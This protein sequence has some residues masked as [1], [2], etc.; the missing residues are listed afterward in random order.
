MTQFR[1]LRDEFQFFDP[2]VFNES[3]LEFLR[4]RIELANYF[5]DTHDEDIF[6]YIPPQ[7]TNQIFTPK[8]VVK[9]M[10]D[11]LEE[12]TPGIFE[13]QDKTFADLYIKSGLYLTE[14]V[15]RLYDGLAE[16][17]PDKDERIKHI[18]EH[19]I[20]GFAPS[21]IIYNIARNF[22]F[23]FDASAKDI[24]DSHVVCLDTTPYA[25]GDGDFEA[26]CNEL[27]GKETK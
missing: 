25:M 9:M 18:L 16:Q 10:V 19:Q 15:K 27:F 17:I 22:I 6:D 3:C 11:K 2:I 13:N 20:Y 12:E 24:D 1:K 26:E 5:D 14:I 8:K 4:K 21:E 7:K 23:G